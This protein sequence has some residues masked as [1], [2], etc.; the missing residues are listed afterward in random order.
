MDIEC[1]HSVTFWQYTDKEFVLPIS[2]SA[3][4]MTK[5]GLLGPLQDIMCVRAF[6]VP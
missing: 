3:C 1:K 5:Q 6:E 4:K 2:S